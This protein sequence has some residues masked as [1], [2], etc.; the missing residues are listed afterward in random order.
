MMKPA[1]LRNSQKFFFLSYD[2]EKGLKTVE[3]KGDED[4]ES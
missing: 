1:W 2:I 3:R 4:D